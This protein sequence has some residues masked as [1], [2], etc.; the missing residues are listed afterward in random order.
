M[1]AA[2][3][4]FKYRNEQT[5]SPQ[6]DQA[7]APSGEARQASPEA[8]HA[9]GRA[10]STAPA[11]TEVARKN[12]TLL[13]E[14]LASRN[15]NDPR[16]DRE[17]KHLDE[18]TREAFREQYRSMARE[19]LNDR[20]TIVFLLGRN[21][22]SAQDVSFLGGVLEERPCLS[23]ASCDRE[24]E[25]PRGEE[26]HLESTNEVTLVYPQLVALHGLEALLGQPGLDPDRREAAKR[27]LQAAQN[28]QSGQ[29][30]DRARG[31]LQRFFPG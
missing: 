24:A 29:V 4:I 25:T 26:V 27:A 13:N 1:G 30:A 15:D 9:S 28:S 5:V 12:V 23:L 7:S 10:G 6:T 22:E 21:L 17:L 31:L 19:K 3:L 16:M 2:L 18:S 20:G 8:H 11:L 14:I